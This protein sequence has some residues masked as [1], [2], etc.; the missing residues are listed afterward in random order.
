M[1][2]GPG[3]YRIGSSVEFDWCCVNAAH[4]LR[5][6]GYR[7]MMVNHNP[8][9]VSTDYDECDRLYL[10]RAL[11]RDSLRDIRQGTAA[12][13]HS[14]HGGTGAQQPGDALPQ[15]GNARAGHLAEGYRPGREPTQVLQPAR[16]IRAYLSPRGGS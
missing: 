15:S 6:L 11:L 16:A 3:A 7:T 5:E 2:L 4:T 13:D 1:I 9:T 10:R 14:V 8:E 12:G